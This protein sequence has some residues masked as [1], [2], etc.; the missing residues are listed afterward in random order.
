MEIYNHIKLKSRR[1][2]LR[3][4]LTVSEASLW[5]YLKGRRFH[6]KK[7]RRQQSIGS[8]IVDFYCPEEKLII[9]LDG[10]V[11]KN[12]KVYREDKK[13]MEYFEEL[14]LKVVRFENNLIYKHL[15]FVLSRIEN[16]MF[17][18]TLSDV[19]SETPP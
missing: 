5:K 12:D 6:N 13:K 2:Q 7:F 16:V 18:T 15:E 10:E 8:Y 1:K 4:N 17:K 9:E 14:D 3:N 19:T 11:H